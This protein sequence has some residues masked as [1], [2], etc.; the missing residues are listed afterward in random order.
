MSG[1]GQDW[2]IANALELV[3]DVLMRERMRPCSAAG[4]ARRWEGSVGTVEHQN[5]IGGSVAAG[6]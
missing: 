1:M 3:S 6:R 4:S 5:P 2:A